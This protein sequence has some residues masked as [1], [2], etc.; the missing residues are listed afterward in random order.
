MSVLSSRARSVASRVQ[1]RPA[2]VVIAAIVVALIIAGSGAGFLLTR[3]GDSSNPAAVTASPTAGADATFAEG[4]IGAPLTLNPLLASTPSEQDLVPLLF[5][6]LVRVDGSGRPQPEL[7]RSWSVSK[8]G[9]TYTFKLRADARWQDGQPITPADVLFTIRLIQ[10]PGFTANPTLA[11]FWRGID[12]TIASSDS[13][14]FHLVRPFSPFPTYLTF[15]ILPKHIIG[16]VMAGDLATSAFSHAPVG[17]GPYQLASWD[18]TKGVITLKRNAYYFGQPVHL[19]R[20][21]IR[22]YASQESL[23]S[24]L[25]AGAIDGTGSL[26]TA[27]LL[28]SDALPATYQIY[29]SALPGYTALFFNTQVAPFNQADVRRAIGMAVDKKSI[30]QG[31][32][33]GHGT[34]GTG[35]IPASSWA[36][37]P[38]TGERF[39]PNGALALLAKAGWTKENGKLVKDGMPLNLP[40]IVNNDDPLRVAAAQQVAQQ[41][42]GIGIDVTLSSMSSADVSRVLASG[43]FTAAVFGWRSITGDPDSYELWNSAGVA[44][45]RNF[46]G[47]HDAK[48]DQ[49]LTAAR[50]T[51]NESERKAL[52][53]AFQQTFAQDSP[54]VILYYPRYLYV[55]SSRI[56]GV[57]SLPII[58][59]ADRFDTIASWYIGKAGPATPAGGG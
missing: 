52:Y 17:S 51:S 39:D 20:I 56:H 50:T 25:K 38:A 48:I 46:T 54:A 27:S 2:R 44:G 13:L 40:I 28:Q 36:Y 19:K 31:A 55:V 23:M 9:L 37:A 21:T 30:V 42:E 53:A 3:P 58:N 10:S 59:A 34:E 57:Q 6:S 26:S 7:A 8:D 1:S 22:Y 12:V 16:D 49:Q 33:S 24:A 43:Q 14:T 35:P 32:L 45:D 29:S 47:L 11:D 15:P 4:D 18:Q 5:R 41:L